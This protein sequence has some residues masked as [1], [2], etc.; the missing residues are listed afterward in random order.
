MADPE[1]RLRAAQKFGVMDM[2]PGLKADTKNAMIEQEQWE[3]LAAQ[4][5]ELAQMAPEQVLMLQQLTVT[6]PGEVYRQAS[7]QGIQAPR[8][9]PAVDDHAVHSREHGIWLKSESSQKLPKAIQ[10]LA[11]AHKAEHDKL[12]ILQVQAMVQ[13]RQPGPTLMTAP[14]QAPKAQNPMTA[15]SSGQRMQGDFAEMGQRAGAMGG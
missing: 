11:E 10:L 6:D 13:G 7:A 8:V 15:G 1:T 4:H 12:A 5:P 9:R 14:A 3:Q 2:L